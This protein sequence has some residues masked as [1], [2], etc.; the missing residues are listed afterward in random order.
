MMDRYAL[1]HHLRGATA[2]EHAALEDV[3]GALQNASDYADYVRGLLAFREPLEN[4]LASI[5]W[6]QCFGDWRPVRIASELRGDLA[7][8]QLT[9]LPPVSVEL[10]NN[11]DSLMGTCY[12]LEGSSLG[13]RVLVGNAIQ[14]GLTAN[15][16]ARHLFA[17]SSDAGNW[18]TFLDLLERNRPDIDV[19]R[20]VAGA[21]T[22]F[23]MAK[24]AM[25]RAK[26]E[27][28]GP[29]ACQTPTFG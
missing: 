5:A 17:Q 25:G 15:H 12:V 18:R 14:L 26:V 3:V 21:K 24:L 7:D 13:A 16:G 2:A 1:R 9:A 28:P 20:V 19:H 22:T 8:L 11:A 10:P 6:P 23:E 29:T 4:H 27:G